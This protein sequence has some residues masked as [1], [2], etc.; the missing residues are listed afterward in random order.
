MSRRALTIRYPGDTRVSRVIV[1]N[2]GLDRLGATLGGKARRIAVVSEPR[3]AALHGARSLRSLR[4]AGHRATLVCVPT[5]ERAKSAAHLARLWSAFAELGIGR[6]DTVVALG[7]GVVGDLAGYAAASWLR[8]VEWIGVPTSMLAQ[9]DSSVGGKTAIDLPEGKNLAGAFHQPSVVVI[10]PEL[11]ATLPMRHLRAG[12]VESVKM[13]MAVDA[14]LFRAVERRIEALLDRDPV[15]LSDVVLRSVRAKA[16]VTRG[17][18][19]ETEGGRRSALNLGHTLGHA[20]E[21]CLGYRR[22][23]HGEAVGL[24]LRVAIRLSVQE[25]GLATETADRMIRILDSLGCPRTIPGLG[26]A[27]LLNAMARDK[28]GRNGKIRWV[29]TPRMG[30]ASVPRLIRSRR[31][32][33]VLMEAGARR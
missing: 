27:P 14:A 31:I 3:V 1:D 11:L 10:D 7:G 22:M 19:R 2:G 28:K 12:L 8:G 32:E 16:R 13:G 30:H 5:G 18:E 6:A 4:R 23:L 17:D 29:L 9:V 24:G 15:A 21:A 20:I 33:A 26:I 25:V